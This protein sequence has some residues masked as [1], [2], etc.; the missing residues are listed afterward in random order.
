M[1]ASGRKRR[2]ESEPTTEATSNKK[3]TGP[4]DNPKCKGCNRLFPCVYCQDCKKPMDECNSCVSRSYQ[5]E[6]CRKPWCRECQETSDDKEACGAGIDCSQIAKCKECL[7]LDTMIT[8][9]E[10]NEE[11]HDFCWEWT[12]GT[13]HSCEKDFC[14]GCHCEH[15]CEEADSEDDNNGKR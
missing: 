3:A 2:S 12:G 5:C 14:N 13:C 1:E 15:N 9:S 10:C 4:S 11:Y 7:K 6:R 8:C